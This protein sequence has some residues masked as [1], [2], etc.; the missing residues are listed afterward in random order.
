MNGLWKIWFHPSFI[1]NEGHYWPL[2]Y[3]SLWL[4]Y[5]F[6]GMIPLGYHLMNL[7]LHGVNSV[8]LFMILKR[9]R[10]PGAWLASAIFALH[11]IHV[12]SVAW[13]IERKDVL[14]GCF[15]LLSVWMYLQFD[16]LGKKNKYYLS[17]FFFICAILSKS[18][19]ISLPLTLILYLWWRKEKIIKKEAI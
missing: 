1:P 13:V 3:T 18:V 2:T 7:A 14:S 17:L 16:D 15:Y 8:L 5:Q 12:E 11:P 9:L 6:W 4:D 10:I 19:P